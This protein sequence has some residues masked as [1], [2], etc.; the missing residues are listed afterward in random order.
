VEPFP[1]RKPLPLSLQ[2]HTRI[3][4]VQ[5]HKPVVVSPVSPEADTATSSF[6]SCMVECMEKAAP[7]NV[8]SKA[9]PFEQSELPPSPLLNSV[10]DRISIARE[11]WT[12]IDI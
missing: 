6:V 10:L 11:R 8:S 7:R 1:F 4:T 5:A 9:E 12:K 2:P 3:G